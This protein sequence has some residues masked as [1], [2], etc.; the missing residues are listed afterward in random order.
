MRSELA[1]FF[2]EN[3]DGESNN[4]M[5]AQLRVDDT[6]ASVTSETKQLPTPT[7]RNRNHLRGLL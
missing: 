3:D 5:R 7:A 1:A 6:H 4:H 2:L